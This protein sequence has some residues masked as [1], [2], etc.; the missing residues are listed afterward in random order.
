MASERLKMENGLRHALEQN[1]FQ[2][3]YQ[4]LVDLE[5]GSIIAME[6]LLRWQ[7]PET[8]LVSPAKFIPIAEETGLIL[9][10]GR[11]VLRAA[12]LQ[13]KQWQMQLGEEI[14]RVVVNLSARQFKGENLVQMINDVLEETGVEAKSLGLEITESIIMEN[15]DQVLETL[16]ELKEMGI[17]LS[18]DDF[19]TGYSSLSYLKSFTID[20][21]KIDRSF[22]RDLA[23]DAD[24]EAIVT[25]ILAMAHSLGVR[26]VAEGVE[27]A[28]QL[29]F[30]KQHGCD[31]YQG[32]YFSK[33][34]PAEQVVEK[35]DRPA[36]LL[37]E[38]V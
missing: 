23:V 11:W 1:E 10:I 31:E 7:H 5:S 34:L 33:P 30:L 15:A 19:G 9:P 17:Q 4:P 24:D 35:L 6:A 3:H 16:T 32:F 18:I 13:H 29:A 12:C 36:S 27:T 28:Q 25:A 8:G 2:L 26:V 22:V 14:P 38:Q 21:L 37:L 20:K